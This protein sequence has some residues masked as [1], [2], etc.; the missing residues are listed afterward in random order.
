MSDIM[1]LLN[2]DSDPDGHGKIRD[3]FENLDPDAAF[4]P[5]FPL[6]DGYKKYQPI[7]EKTIQDEKEYM[8]ESV[9]SK[10][11]YLNQDRLIADYA[12]SAV[13][14]DSILQTYWPYG[15]KETVECLELKPGDKLLEVGIGTGM[16]LEYYPAGCE[17]TGID[18]CEK[19]LE[20]AK[21]KV[22]KGDKKVELRLMDSA[23]MDFPDDSFNKVLCF[24]ALCSMK[25]PLA[26]LQEI[27]RVCGPG[28]KVVILEVMLSPIEEVA[29][30]QLLFRPVNRRLDHVYIEGFPVSS[31]PFD[32]GLDILGL[33]KETSIKPVHTEYFTS[34]EWVGL[35]IGE[36]GA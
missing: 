12:R 10:Q 1:H 9:N 16:N 25:S 4:Q 5:R 26:T 15:R 18:L 3:Y 36:N 28:S 31:V 6:H 19:M 13:E 22:G 2:L 14:Y 11:G 33:L 29:T 21:G 20:V 7:I 34:T 27:S 8:P 35:V 17:I 32:C 24:W 30:L 23:Q